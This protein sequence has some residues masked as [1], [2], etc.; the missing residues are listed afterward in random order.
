MICLG[1]VSF[2]DSELQLTPKS[3]EIHFISHMI[4]N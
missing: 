4:H 2:Y 1:Q 3:L